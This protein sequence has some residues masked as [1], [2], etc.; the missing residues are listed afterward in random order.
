MYLKFKL[1]HTIQKIF[2]KITK[3]SHFLSRSLCSYADN[4]RWSGREALWRV[5][6]VLSATPL[7]IKEGR[8][9]GN[10]RF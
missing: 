2:E 6:C 5:R 3:K 4:G 9:V 1:A 10:L 8:D 7:P